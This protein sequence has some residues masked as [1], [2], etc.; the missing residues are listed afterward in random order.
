LPETKSAALKPNID[1]Y[2]PPPIHP[3][4]RQIGEGP[5]AFEAFEA[6][7]DAGPTRSIRPASAKLGKSRILLGRWSVTWCWDKRA[8]RYDSEQDRVRREQHR[9]KLDK[10]YDTQARIANAMASKLVDRIRTLNVEEIT[11]KEIAVWFKVIVDVQRQA[12]GE[13]RVIRNKAGR[14]YKD[15]GAPLNFP[16]QAVANARVAAEDGGIGEEGVGTH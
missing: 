11:A 16:G 8:K 15:D 7:L 12:L 9:A 13:R 14:P 1:A 4:D 6:Y 5:E 2:A 3:W 10:M